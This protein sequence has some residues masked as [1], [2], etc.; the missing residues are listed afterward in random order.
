MKYPNLK[1]LINGKASR[2]VVAFFVIC[3]VVI[4]GKNIP[5]VKVGKNTSVYN[6]ADISALRSVNKSICRVTGAKPFQSDKEILYFLTLAGMQKEILQ[7]EKVLP[8]KEEMLRGVEAAN[9]HYAG[10]LTDIKKELGSDYYRIFIEPI[11]ISSIFANYY[12]AKEPNRQAA[13]AFLSKA[14]SSGLSDS[15]R[16]ENL[17]ITETAVPNMPAN[18]RAFQGLSSVLSSK[19]SS[20]VFPEI[21]EDIDS[22]SIMKP[23][24]TDQQA[25]IV[26]AVRIRKMTFEEFVA[27]EAAKKQIPVEV[28]FYSPYTRSSLAKIEKSFLAIDKATGKEKE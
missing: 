1:S 14:L 2:V 19:D 13:Q 10:L 26:D 27:T 12:T 18:A 11:G 28:S 23:K 7:A 3:A 4:V 16:A 24:R 6:Y 22:Y 15:A 20:R 17:T 21:I 8:I 25:I 9:Q 5:L